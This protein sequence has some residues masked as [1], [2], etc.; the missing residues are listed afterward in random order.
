MGVSGQS[1]DLFGS[2]TEIIANGMD[3]GVRKKEE[4]KDNFGEV[5]LSN[6]QC[7]NWEHAGR[8]RLIV[9]NQNFHLALLCTCF[10]IK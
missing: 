3:G 6:Q 9:E 8:S 5:G 7:N 4:S 2:G 10:G 1:L